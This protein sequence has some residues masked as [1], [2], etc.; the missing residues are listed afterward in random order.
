M[1]SKKDLKYYLK[2]VPE[3]DDIMVKKLNT[4]GPNSA[5]SIGLPSKEIYEMEVS[6]SFWTDSVLFGG[7]FL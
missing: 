6:D 3:S 5:F 4:I 1:V 2:D 7:I